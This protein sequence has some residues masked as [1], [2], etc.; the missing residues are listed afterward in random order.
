LSHKRL[1]PR[2][3]NRTELLRERKNR[4]LLEVTRALI[5]SIKV[6]KKY[7]SDALCTAFVYRMPTRVLG[8]PYHILKPDSPPY[9]L[10]PL[11]FGCVCKVPVLDVKRDN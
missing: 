2:P 8:G 4:H 10:V 3:P 5:T 7:W 1:V 11:V 9:S 6:P